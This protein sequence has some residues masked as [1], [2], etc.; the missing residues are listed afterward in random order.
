MCKV[1]LFFSFFFKPPLGQ[2]LMDA[3][4]RAHILA[5]SSPTE[6]H[7]LLSHP[8][9]PFCSFFTFLSTT[10]LARSLPKRNVSCYLCLHQ[11]ARRCLDKRRRRVEH[12]HTSK[13]SCGKLGLASRAQWGTRWSVE[14][15][16]QEKLLKKVLIV[17]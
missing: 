9:G 17:S 16:V 12:W 3:P 8:I 11:L 6:H 13:K 1:V 5:G 4:G 15:F 14:G 7:G 2:L 10:S